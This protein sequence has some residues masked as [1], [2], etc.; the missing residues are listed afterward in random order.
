MTRTVHPEN[1]TGL[2]I[3]GPKLKTFSIKPTLLDIKPHIKTNAI[4]GDFN[5]PPM[6]GSLKENLNRTA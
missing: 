5:N 1:I 2:N 3:Y 6:Y 4:L